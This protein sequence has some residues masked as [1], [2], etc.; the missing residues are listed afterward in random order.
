MDATPL[1][2]VVIPTY[3]GE[4]FLAQTLQCVLAQTHPAV[5][6]IVV[7]DGSTD[8]SLDLARQ[9]APQ[10]VQIVQAN[11][12]VSTA[13]NRGL[14]AAHGRYVIFLDQDDIWH[15]L[16]L[17]R[18]VAWL[19]L[20]P[21][22]GA[23]VCPYHHWYADDGGYPEPQGVWPA[24]PGLLVDPEFS[25]WVYHQFLF[26][27]WA[28]TS[29]TLMRREAV[30]V[31][32]GF[33]TSLPF[34]EDWDLW[35]RLSLRAPF[36]LLRWPPVLYRQHPVQGSRTVRPK[37]FRT[38]LLLR[39]GARH[40]LASADG[41]AMDPVRFDGLLARYQSSFGYHHLQHGNRWTGVRSLL[42]AWWRRPSRWKYLVMAL[43]VIVGWRP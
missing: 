12:G 27:C 41:R 26:D 10:A 18:Q 19:K 25:G 36:A 31:C 14:A 9:V 43:A 7:D 6:I 40:G 21:E 37:D 4:R 5:E 13:R 39:Y 38:E 16:Q 23:V 35:L 28:L 20:H 3:N 42:A 24:D 29:G 32:G 30:E 2:S 15:P 11:A 34:S 8:G 33:D 17:E 1:V 22:C